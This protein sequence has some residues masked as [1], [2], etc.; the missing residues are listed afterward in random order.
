MEQLK[1][2]VPYSGSHEYHY[3][4]IERFP[5]KIQEYV[6]KY[7]EGRDNKEIGMLYNIED[8]KPNRMYHVTYSLYTPSPKP[9]KKKVFKKGRRLKPYPGPSRK[10]S[11]IRSLIRR[12][13]QYWP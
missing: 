3:K 1:T 4:L 11:S 8:D 10:P 2:W 7:I 13:P 12:I 9:P 6:I 5:K